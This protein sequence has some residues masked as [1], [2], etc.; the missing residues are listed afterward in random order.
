MQCDFE[1]LPCVDTLQLILRD[2]LEMLGLGRGYGELSWCPVRAGWPPKD[3]G[4]LVFFQDDR[5]IIDSFWVPGFMLRVPCLISH[6]ILQQLYDIGGSTVAPVCRTVDSRFCSS[7]PE[8]LKMYCLA[9]WSTG[10][11]VKHVAF[12][13]PSKGKICTPS[14]F[15][16]LESLKNHDP[17]TP[18]YF[19][20]S[21]QSRGRVRLWKSKSYIQ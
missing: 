21:L 18:G 9:P 10:T 14:F 15:F 4:L 11:L 12:T 7:G 16:P 2:I 20:K 5:R 8:H 19:K 13:V 1:W 17:R 6:L 3:Q